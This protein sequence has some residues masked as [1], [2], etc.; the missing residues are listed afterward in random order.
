M[1]RGMRSKHG[2]ASSSL[3]AVGVCLLIC[4]ITSHSSVVI[5][6]TPNSAQMRLRGGA[7]EASIPRKG[8][9][10]APL[11]LQQELETPDGRSAPALAAYPNLSLYNA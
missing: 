4:Q 7:R 11:Q 8:D 3:G 6:K 2:I 10:L 1:I 9:P 5:R